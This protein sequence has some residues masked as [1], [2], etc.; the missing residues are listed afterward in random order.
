MRWL[1]GWP[2]PTFAPGK[3][4]SFSSISAKTSSRGRMSARG[5]GLRPLAVWNFSGSFASSVVQISTS[6]SEECT[7]SACSSCS[8]PCAPSDVLHLRNR[9]DRLLGPCGDAV[10]FLKRDSRREHEGH[11]RGA[12]VEGRQELRAEPR[13]DK[14]RDD[15]EPTER[16]QHR[17][18]ARHRDRVGAASASRLQKRSSGPS[19]PC[20]ILL[21]PGSR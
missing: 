19:F 5:G 17:D 12:L 9:E 2:T 10:R 11:R 6:I 8:A 4:E 14:D 7:P 3:T 16:G 15:D 21:M 20:S 1:I 13:D 18:R